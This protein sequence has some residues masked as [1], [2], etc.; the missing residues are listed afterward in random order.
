MSAMTSIPL[1][2]VTEFATNWSHLAQQKLSKVKEYVT[3]DTVN[4]KEKSF[5]QIGEM[6]MQRVTLRAGE[7]RIT[8]TPLSKRWLRPYP[9]DVA[10]LFDEFDADFLGQIVLPTSE[11]VQAH[12]A[13]YNRAVDRTIIE[14]ALNA[15]YTGETG[16]TATALPAGQEIAVNYVETGAAA[17]AGLTIGKLRRAKFLFDNAEVDDEEPRCMAVCAQQLQDLLRTTEVTSADYNTVRALVEGKIDTFMGFKFKRI[18][19]NILPLVAATDVRTCVAWVKSGV[20]IADSGRTTMMD[21]RADKSHAL[22]IRSKASLGGTR[23]EEVK[24]VAVY[25]DESP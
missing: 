3:V 11:T 17:N 22:Q 24:V 8:D 4:G 1:H 23:T 6:E 5:N 10:S 16:V 18:S 19:K 21:V 9:H 13:A 12:V 20:K 2:F 15:A 14:S 25:C 7:T